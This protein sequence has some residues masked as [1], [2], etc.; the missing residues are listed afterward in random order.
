MLSINSTIV[1]RLMSRFF[2]SS[3]SILD[4]LSDSIKGKKNNWIGWL[5]PNIKHYN[6]GK[7]IDFKITNFK[8]RNT[9]RIPRVSYYRKRR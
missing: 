9:P 2:E 5:K 8:N 6:T 4:I 7:K 3:F 1:H